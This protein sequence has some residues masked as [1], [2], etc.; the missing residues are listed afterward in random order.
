[1]NHVATAL[2]SSVT[3]QHVV[4]VHHWTDQLF[5]LRITRPASL[6]FRSGE[7]VMLGLMNGE[8]GR[9]LLRAYSIASPCWDE[10]LDFY[11]I[12]VPDGPLTSRL[13]DVKP[14]DRV[15]LGRKPTGT[16][17]L[18]ALLPG[19]RLFM[20]STGTGIA[21]FASLIRDPET[22]EK[23]DEVILTETCR[24]IADLA[25][26]SQ[27]TADLQQDPLI[28]EM[29]EGRFR[30]YQSVTREDFARKG[31]I[32]FLIRSGQLFHD[33]G[34]NGFDP[35]K[36]RIM[37]CGSMQMI[38][39]TKE[40]AEAAGFEEGSNAAPGSFVVEKAFAG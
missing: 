35:A 19:R 22:Y 28:G 24:N 20:L 38:A 10:E 25:Y 31:R 34:I 1:M 8:T 18:D 2:P 13:K 32:T 12:K 16:L 39:D 7:F 36:D 9:P 40:I 11:S 27:L 17:V 33:L 5:S 3:E 4:N 14:G 21:P 37:I 15:V 23:F 26:G 29:V 6:R 30:H